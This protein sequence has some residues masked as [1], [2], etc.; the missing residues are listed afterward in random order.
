MKLIWL[1][2]R[3][4]AFVPVTSNSFNPCHE[5]GAIISISLFESISI[6]IYILPDRPVC[7]GSFISGRLI[8][9]TP[10]VRENSLIGC[11]ATR[12]ESEKIKER[13][14]E[15]GLVATAGVDENAAFASH[16]VS[17]RPLLSFFNECTVLPPAGVGLFNKCRAVNASFRPGYGACSVLLVVLPSGCLRY[18]SMSKRT[19]HCHK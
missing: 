10:A 4:R 7:V 9:L 2:T 19:D 6:Y 12:R 3:S 18:C 11:S 1:L 8:T 14:Q 17:V 5:P 15:T 16:F 13:V